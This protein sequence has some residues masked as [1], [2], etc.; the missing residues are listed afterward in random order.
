MLEYNGGFHATVAGEWRWLEMRA[1]KMLEPPNT[2]AP[3]F[4]AP[5]IGFLVIFNTYEADLGLEVAEFRVTRP[6]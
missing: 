3:M 2:E 6:G 5:W 1:D 4:G